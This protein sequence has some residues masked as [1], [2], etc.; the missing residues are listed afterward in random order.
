LMIN[1]RRFFTTFRMTWNLFIDEGERSFE[2]ID[3]K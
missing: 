2:Y 1:S 3:D